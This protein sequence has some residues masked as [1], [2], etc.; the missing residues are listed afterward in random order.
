MS[1]VPADAARSEDG[2]WW[3]DGN[4]WQPINPDNWALLSVAADALARDRLNSIELKIT[5]VV[6]DFHN[7]AKQQ[8][9]AHIRGKSEGGTFEGLL[10]VVATVAVLVI[11][12]EA[13]AAKF[14]A[15]VLK[16]AVEYE[17]VMRKGVNSYA[18]KTVAQRVEDAKDNMISILDEM[19]N[20][21][22]TTAHDASL[23][24]KQHLAGS[25]QAFIQEEPNYR[26]VA[27][28]EV[29]T[30]AATVCDLIGIRDLEAANFS[31]AAHL[32]ESLWKEFNKDFHKATATL[33]FWNMDNDVERLLF[34]LEHVEGQSDV[35]QYLHL[36]GADVP[37][38]QHRVAYFHEHFA[39]EEPNGMN[40]LQVITQTAMGN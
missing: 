1:N 24:G 13:A 2:Q 18:A 6:A 40:T 30:H 31:F 28:D 19:A 20:D 27:G 37:W 25:L 22:A 34:L 12:P 10:G 15:E 14:G 26:H 8:I 3:W 36:V 39:G 16:A 7:L 5:E 35:G 21:A 17:E 9:E 29:T 33:N 4:G 32:Y 38:W 23:A 11:A